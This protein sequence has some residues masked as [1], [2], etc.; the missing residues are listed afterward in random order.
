MVVACDGRLM[1]EGRGGT[2]AKEGAG[3]VAG[4]V[5][6]AVEDGCFGLGEGRRLGLLASR[7]RD[8]ELARRHAFATAHPT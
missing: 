7:E 5:R 1:A 3:E 6:R 8:R 4:A 2:R